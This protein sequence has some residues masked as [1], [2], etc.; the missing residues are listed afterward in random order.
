VTLTYD[1]PTQKK[2]AIQWATH[3]DPSIS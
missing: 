1:S 3:I 2:Q